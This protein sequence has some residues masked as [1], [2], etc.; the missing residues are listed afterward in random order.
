MCVCRNVLEFLIDLNNT[1]PDGESLKTRPMKT[2]PLFCGSVQHDPLPC[3]NAA[4]LNARHKHTHTHAL[5]H[6][7]A[8]SPQALCCGG[9]SVD[10]DIIIP[11]PLSNITE[12][13]SGNVVTG[14][15]QHHNTMAPCYCHYC[16]TTTQKERLR[17]TT[18]E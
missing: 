4:G 15:K 6:P 2:A 11:R 14:N 3:A 12:K 13:Q 5:T 8:S 16:T 10:S 18:I 7:L 17:G 1:D 9:N